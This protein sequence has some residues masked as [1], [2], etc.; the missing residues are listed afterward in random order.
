M[1][2]YG[3]QKKKKRAKNRRI[4]IMEELKNGRIEEKTNVLKI[5]GLKQ[6][7]NKRMRE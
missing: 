5:E 4:K 1:K 2:G 3:V 7:N 6:W